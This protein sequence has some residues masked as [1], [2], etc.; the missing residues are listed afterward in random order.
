MAGK[1]SLESR[2]STLKEVNESIN[3]KGDKIKQLEDSYDKAYDKRMEVE[4][5]DN[6]DDEVKNAYREKS[7]ETL[8]GFIEKGKDAANDLNKELN[9]LKELKQ[10]NDEAIKANA[11]GKKRAEAMDKAASERNIESNTA[12]KFVSHDEV[13]NKFGGEIGD[14]KKQVEALQKSAG[15]L[16]RFRDS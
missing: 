7:A 12:E 9:K 11:E 1:K 13:L 3:E 5:D 16:K 4:N 10:E 2:K 8:R 6:I 14:A 15:N